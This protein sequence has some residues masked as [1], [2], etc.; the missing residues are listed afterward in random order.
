M[1]RASALR[2]IS[3]VALI[4]AVVPRS[5]SPAALAEKRAKSCVVPKSPVM[6]RLP[7]ETIRSPKP[8]LISLA[9]L[10][11]VGVGVDVEIGLSGS[12]ETPD[13]TN[14]I[15]LSATSVTRFV[16]DIAPLLTNRSVPPAIV[17]LLVPNWSSDPICSTPASM[18]VTPPYVLVP[19]S[20][21]LLAPSFVRDPFPVMSPE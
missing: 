1:N 12:M 19:L 9:T 10:A 20:V 15:A 13:A 2:L 4:C 11:T 17:M 6:V 21:R 16:K 3:P 5:N 7:S 14:S 18:R 8:P